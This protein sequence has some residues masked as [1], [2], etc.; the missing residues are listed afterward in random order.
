MKQSKMIIACILMMFGILSGCQSVF[1]P[2]D[3]SFQ[4]PEVHEGTCASIPNAYR[5][6]LTG[7]S[8]PD[9]EC[10]ECAEN[11]D[12]DK[13]N[14][15]GAAP[16][17][18]SKTLYQEKRF[19]KLHTLIEADHPPIVV[20]PEVVRVLV[21][22]YTGRENEMFGFRYI[23]FFATNPSWLLSTTTENDRGDN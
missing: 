3:D 8:L 13:L 6:S 5:Q 18:D 2:Y 7:K 21:M 11:T 22:S 4:C 9:Q 1:N 17:K 15:H 14:E 23:Y 19:E 12:E 10:S 20:P 16:S